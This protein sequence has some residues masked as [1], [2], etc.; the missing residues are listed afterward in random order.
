MFSLSV[1]NLCHGAIDSLQLVHAA[2]L[3]AQAGAVPSVRAGMAGGAQGYRGM[4]QALF[5]FVHMARPWRITHHTCKGGYALY[6]AALCCGGLWF[7][8]AM[9][10]A[11]STVAISRF[12]Y[13]QNLRREHL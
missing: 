3:P 12:C 2:Q 5:W 1:R 10:C 13:T 11:L 9:H 4:P 7:V 6:V 8:F